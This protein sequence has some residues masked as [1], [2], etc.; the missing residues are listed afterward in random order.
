MQEHH[1]DQ[2][3]QDDQQASDEQFETGLQVIVAA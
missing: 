1:E 3:K 2:P